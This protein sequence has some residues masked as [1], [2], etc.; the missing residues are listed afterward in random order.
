MPKKIA[1]LAMLLQAPL[2]SAP[3]HAAPLSPAATDAAAHALATYPQ[4]LTASLAAMVSYNT[5]ADPAVPFDKN[6]QHLGFKQ[7]LKE[8]AA[9][10]GFDFQDDGY[11]VVI[12]LGQ[13]TERVGIIT[14]GDVQPVNPA[15]WAKS[16]FELDAASEPGRLIARGAEDDKGR[17]RP[18]CMR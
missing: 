18:R 8:E 15:K 16:P 12:G 6:P 5:V 10:L 9:R 11:V 3:L 17:W 4:Q 1:I 13:G 2:F 14:H 7:F